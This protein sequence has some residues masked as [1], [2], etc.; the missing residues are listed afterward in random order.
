MIQSLPIALPQ[1]KASN[2]YEKLLNEI[3][4]IIFSLYKAKYITKK[5]YNKIYRKII[6]LEEYRKMIIQ[7]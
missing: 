5:E 3:Q 7:K 6:Y 4:Q 1:V 2:T